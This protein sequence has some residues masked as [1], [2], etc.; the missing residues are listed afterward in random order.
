MLDKGRGTKRGKEDRINKVLS[1]WLWQHLMGLGNK[2]APKLNVCLK[3][4]W[5][6]SRCR[7][8][9]SVFPLTLLNIINLC[10]RKLKPP[11]SHRPPISVQRCVFRRPGFLLVTMCV[12]FWCCHTQIAYNLLTC[13]K[14]CKYFVFHSPS[15]CFF[16]LFFSTGLTTTSW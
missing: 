13:N 10:D 6:D 2:T 5:S 1:F 14:L 16:P 3:L 9:T 7:T 15:I 11:C 4:V 8:Q 12:W